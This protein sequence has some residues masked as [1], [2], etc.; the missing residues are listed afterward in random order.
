MAFEWSGKI[1][2]FIC[3]SELRLG[4]DL[5]VLENSLIALRVMTVVSRSILALE[6]RRIA[7]V[8]SPVGIFPPELHLPSGLPRGLVRDPQV[9]ISLLQLLHSLRGTE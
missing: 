6:N 3:N 2:Q 4:P 5:S 7:F 8:S 1:I 9:P